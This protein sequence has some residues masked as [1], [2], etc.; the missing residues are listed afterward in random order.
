MF[1]LKMTKNDIYLVVQP[2]KNVF[3]FK[4]CTLKKCMHAPM[5]RIDLALSVS[6]PLT[7]VSTLV[8]LKIFILDFAAYLLDLEREEK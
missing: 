7:F 5:S 2:K 1:S 4:K 3:F 8:K 6:A